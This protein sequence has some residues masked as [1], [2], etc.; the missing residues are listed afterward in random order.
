MSRPLEGDCE[1][2]LFDFETDKGR[3]TFWHSS[4]HILG[5]SLEMIYG[6]KLCTGSCNRRKEAEGFYYDAYYG[7]MTLNKDQFDLIESEVRKAVASELKFQRS[8]PLIC[9]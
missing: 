3:D 2:M 5:Q 6:C 1:L 8:R 4:A 7:E 9:F